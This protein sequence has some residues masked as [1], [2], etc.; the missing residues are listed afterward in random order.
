MLYTRNIT[1]QLLATQASKVLNCSSCAAIF[2]YLR[3]VDGAVSSFISNRLFGG[4]Y[5][6]WLTNTCQSGARIFLC[7]GY[8]EPDAKLAAEG[9][10]GAIAID[11]YDSF[12]YLWFPR[13]LLLQTIGHRY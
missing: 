13:L 7:N 9:A 8:P 11:I 1:F 10:N 2:N 4:K 5:M 12:D 3:K 6:L